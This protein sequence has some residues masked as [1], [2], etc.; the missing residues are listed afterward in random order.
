MP[1]AFGTVLK[2]LLAEKSD[3]FTEELLNK[4]CH[5]IP[6]QGS[7]ASPA[8]VYL[9]SLGLKVHWIGKFDAPLS[10]L[11]S[12]ESYLNVL[13]QNHRDKE[14]F[15]KQLS[16][17]SPERLEVFL[18]TY[19]EIIRRN[20]PFENRQATYKDITQ[21]VSTGLALVPLDANLLFDERRDGVDP[22]MVVVIGRG[23]APHPKTGRSC[24]G[25][26]FHNTDEV[27]GDIP[28]QFSFK[29]DFERARRTHSDQMSAFGVSNF[30]ISVLASAGSLFFARPGE[31]YRDRTNNT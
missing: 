10:T 27:Y 22:H 23:T 20:I 12:P 15:E 1:T 24:P 29:Q 21:M 14:A 7:P 4:V 26:I 16:M 19:R 9:H 2:T 5:Y 25:V 11:T 18:R 30:P 8:I 31:Y 28:Y 13:R 17:L 3:T 6:G